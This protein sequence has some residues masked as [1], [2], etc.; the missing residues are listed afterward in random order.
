MWTCEQHA[1]ND[2]DIVC[3]LTRRNFTFLPGFNKVWKDV[4][5]FSQFNSLYVWRKFPFVGIAFRFEDVNIVKPGS[6]WFH[7]L[8]SK[9]IHS[10][11]VVKV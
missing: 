8:G 11:A 9:Y 4:G 6:F 2:R 10:K 5:N 3:Q 7:V 1:G